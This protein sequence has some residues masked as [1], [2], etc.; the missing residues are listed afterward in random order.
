[1]RILILDHLLKLASPGWRSLNLQK[2]N[3]EEL[4]FDDL[5][6]FLYDTSGLLNDPEGLLGL[7]LDNRSEVDAVN[8]LKAAFEA[9]MEEGGLGAQNSGSDPLW[10]R[11]GHESKEAARLLSEGSSEGGNSE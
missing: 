5:L 7:T 2:G 6:N 4:D 11:I 9:A 3:A 8:R 1:M 10:D